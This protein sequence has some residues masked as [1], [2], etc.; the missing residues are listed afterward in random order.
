MNLIIHT[1]NGGILRVQIEPHRILMQTTDTGPGIPNVDLAQ[2]AGWSTAT[3]EV[4]DM[5]FGAG[6]GL[7][8]MR[9]C[10]DRM[11]LESTPGK[12]TRLLMEI[13]LSEDER[14]KESDQADSTSDKNGDVK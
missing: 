13:H 3:Q 8:N 6:M 9:R 7:V 2:Q 14:F 1:D 11:E 10:V 4:R 5:G 12:G